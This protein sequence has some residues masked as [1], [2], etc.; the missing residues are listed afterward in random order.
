[1]RIIDAGQTGELFSAGG[2]C[3]DS[4][5]LSSKWLSVVNK[6]A[7][8]SKPHD[9]QVKALRD[10]RMLESRRNLIISGPTNSG[11]S[12]LGYLAVLSGLTGGRRALL[13]EPFR[14]LAQEKFGELKELLPPIDK[15][16]TD[17]P[18]V[19]ITTGDYRLNGETLMIEPP[20][21]GEIV[22]A[23]PERIDAIMRNPDY[24]DWISSFGI[25]CVDEA[26]LIGDKHRGATLEGV[27]TRFLSE[28]AP[29]RFILL[30]ATL[31]NCDH[32]VNWLEPCDIALSNVRRPALKQTIAVIEKGENTNDIIVSTLF[33]IFDKEKSSVL[34]FVYRTADADRLAQIISMAFQ[35]KYGTSV[36][37]AYHS[38]LPADKK[39][40][41][42]SDYENGNFR[43]LVSTTALGAGV[44]LPATHVIIRDLT[45]A[46][47][48][49]LSI[50]NILQMMGRAGR[51]NTP[52]LATAILKPNDHWE[53][54]TLADQVK[55]P[56][57]PDVKSTL[58]ANEAGQ[59]SAVPPAAKLVMGQLVRREKQTLSDLIQFFNKSLGAKKIGEQID[60]AVSWLLDGQRLL[61][62]KNEEEI[63]AT[64]LGEAIARAGIPLDVGAAFGS[65]LRDILLCDDENNILKRWK[66]IDTLITL[67]LLSPR[68]KGLRR[69]SIKMTEQI[70]AWMERYSERPV[71]Y[72]EWIRGTFQASKA[73]EII[74]SLGIYLE[75]KK[76]K[77][78]IA[79]EMAYKAIIRSIVIYQLG[80]G[81]LIKDIERKWQV[82]GIEGVAERWR[83]HLL[84]LLAGIS[85]IL[86]IRCFY[87]CLREECKASD[88]RVESVKTCLKNMRRGVY[89]LL[90]LL[91]FCSPLGPIFRDL[92]AARA[93]VGMRTKEKLEAAGI[94]SLKDINRL[95]LDK[96][97]SIGVRRDIAKKLMGYAKRRSL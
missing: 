27:I 63:G 19:E 13:I 66:P 50:Q 78:Q 7:P 16:A 51:G 30:S 59:F 82:S 95:D 86:E 61:A 2:V 65:L 55:S 12:L 38:K 6:I 24:D 88:D 11:K 37:A 70:D 80:S 90:G 53:E 15:W 74:G 81:V 71:L 33:S 20:R 9:V 46:G 85:E 77:N 42:K 22:I 43:C 93:G 47:E 45:F 48:G 3:W 69:F 75:G 26:H 36:A 94:S 41:I 79:W 72:T 60:S 52:G 40:A 14:A 39:H 35:E 84:W 8:G 62:W 67:E 58:I 57:L 96:I 92:E 87:Y 21:N 56:T 23:T 18:G 76:Q 49:A 5:G 97:C 83:D 64:R 73:E 68:E 10:C 28:K 34:V 54:K 4:L 25:I 89:K 29:P 1:M 44:N 31:G 17:L 32:I 91:R